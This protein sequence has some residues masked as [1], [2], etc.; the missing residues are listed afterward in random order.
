MHSLI[1]Q[2]FL[3]G[4]LDIEMSYGDRKGRNNASFVV[5]Y[6]GQSIYSSSIYC[7]SIYSS[8]KRR[9]HLHLSTVVR[10]IGLQGILL[11]L[12]PSISLF[13]VN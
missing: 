2:L 12:A 3:F 7:S 5:V 6:I 4:S 11:S 13:Y 10:T 8:D 9:V 1:E